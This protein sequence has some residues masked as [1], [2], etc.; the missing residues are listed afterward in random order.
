MNSP[1]PELL[2]PAGSLQKLEYA[3]AFGADATYIG[4]PYYSLRAR[5]NEF[6]LEE[7]KKGITLAHTLGKKIYVTSNIF[8][9][10]RKI[11]PFLTQLKSWIDLKPDALIMSDPGLM[12]TVR[13]NFPDFPIHLS[14]QANCM[15]WKSVK[16]W[17]NALNIERIILSRELPIQEIREIKDKVPDIEL[18]AF[19]HGSICMAYSGRCLLSSYMSYRDANQGVCDNSC[20]EKYRVHQGSTYIE[21]MR[22]PGE[23]YPIEEDEEGTYILNAK[24][25]CL[26]EHLKE[27]HEAGVCSFKVE[28]RTKSVNYVSLVSK[29]YRKAIDNMMEGKPFD[30]QTL[31]ELKKTAHRDFHKGFFQ[32]EPGTEG[33]NYDTSLPRISSRHFAGLIATDFEKDSEL[34]RSGFIPIE[35]RGTFR[36]GQT[37]EVQSPDEFPAQQ[38]VVEEIINKKSQPVEAAHSGSGIYWVKGFSQKPRLGIVSLIPS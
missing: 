2:M 34:N 38:F 9:R 10:N 16:F 18:E 13:E 33:Q 4:V 15:N 8:A 22:T 28:G 23:L 26:I 17:K 36:V 31:E 35:A 12:L 24:D 30:P 3:Y 11:G 32:G 29:A 1:K 7:L 37:L 25:L 27:L 21:D 5:E 20:R 19:V 6:G 14:V